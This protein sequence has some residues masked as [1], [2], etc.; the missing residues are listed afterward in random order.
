MILS[1]HL[2]R[3]GVTHDARVYFGEKADGPSGGRYHRWLK[4]YKRRRERQRARRNP[5]CVPA[6]GRYYGW[7]L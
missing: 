5:E 3:L 2:R 7:E 4:V 6:Y 1:R